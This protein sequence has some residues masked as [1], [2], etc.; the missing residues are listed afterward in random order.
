VYHAYSGYQVN[1]LRLYF[2]FGS[3]ARNPLELLEDPAAHNPCA[4][5]FHVISL[6]SSWGLYTC[7]CT[8]T[9]RIFKA[10]D[11]L[12]FTSPSFEPQTMNF[13]FWYT[14][15]VGLSN[16]PKMIGNVL[17]YWVLPYYLCG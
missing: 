15:P 5:A 11:Y 12:I 7:S 17:I 13:S 4:G 2:T 6:F 8:E 3:G 1:G 10:A 9:L 14:L 16:L